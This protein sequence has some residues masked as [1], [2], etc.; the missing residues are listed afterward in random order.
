MPTL[1]QESLTGFAFQLLTAACVPSEKADLVA[2][3]LVAAN[4]RGVDS[5]GL[6]LL[7]YY[8]EQLQMGNINPRT[9]GHVVSEDGA[10][11]V[12]DGERGIGQ[13]ISAICSDHAV[14][15]AGVHG[16]GMAVARESSHFGAA[17]FWAA[18]MSAKGS[19]GI[20]MCNASPLVAPWQGKEPR[21]GTNPIAMSLPGQNTWLLDMATTTVALGKILNAQNH[22][23]ATIPEGWAMDSDGVPTTSTET[24]L[25]GLLMPL[26]GYKGSGLAMMAEIL[27]AVLSGGA[28]STQLGGIRVQGQPM[29]TSQFFLAM[30]VARCMPLA[31]FESRVRELAAMVKS[32]K[33]AAGYDQILV[34]GEPE[35]ETE[36]LRR[37][38]GIP[39]S[40]GVWQNLM[41]CA[42][43]LGVALPGGAEPIV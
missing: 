6:Q 38:N 20:V 3:S 42:R 19:I 33:T 21:F 2:R 4:L 25:S 37:R 39:L 10:C 5:H 41:E 18:R 34:A 7:P 31:D 12:Y 15:L 16:L 13:W 28:M 11:L 23:R 35:W 24:A 1:P 43:Q 17:A 22:G 9:D 14:R 32:S 36:E 8:L 27:C 30:D 26:G 40:D 29:R